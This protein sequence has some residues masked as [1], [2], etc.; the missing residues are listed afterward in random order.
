MEQRPRPIGGDKNRGTTLLTIS[1]T[2]AAICI[3]VVA[4][5]FYARSMIHAVGKDDWI[6]LI[7]L[8]HK[9]LNS[10]EKAASGSSHL[11]RFFCS[12]MLALRRSE[13]LIIMKD[14]S[15]T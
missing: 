15:S 11:S 3:I 12:S 10:N 9:D 2:E 4:V 1:W 14:I 7:T 8:V 6:M 13:Q 5:R